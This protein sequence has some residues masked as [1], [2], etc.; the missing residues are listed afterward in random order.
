MR[1]AIVVI[2]AAATFATACGSVAASGAGDSS[3]DRIEELRALRAIGADRRY[4]RIEE[5]RGIAQSAR[6]I[7]VSDDSYDKVEAH[8][9]NRGK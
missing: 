8:R 5:L 9:L 7:D 2:L 4:D 3:Y 1:V 6:T